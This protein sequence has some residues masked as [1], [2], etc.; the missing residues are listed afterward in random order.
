MVVFTSDG[1]K[2][3]VLCMTMVHVQSTTATASFAAD[4]DVSKLFVAAGDRSK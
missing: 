1:D 4:P 2:Q 3:C